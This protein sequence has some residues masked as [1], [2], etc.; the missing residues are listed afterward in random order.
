MVLISKYDNI[1]FGLFLFNGVSKLDIAVNL[2]RKW[3]FS[4]K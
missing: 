4:P 3:E 2:V 1:A